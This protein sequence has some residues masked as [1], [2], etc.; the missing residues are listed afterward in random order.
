MTAMGS[1]TTN[2]VPF[3]VALPPALGPARARLRRLREL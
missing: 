2:V 1:L 3:A